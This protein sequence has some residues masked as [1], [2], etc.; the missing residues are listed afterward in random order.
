MAIIFGLSFIAWVYYLQNSRDLTKNIQPKIIINQKLA[1]DPINNHTT[2]S[3]VWEKI[4]S[5]SNNPDSNNTS[6]LSNES[7]QITGFEWPQDWYKEKKYP[8]LKSEPQYAFSVPSDFNQ[9]GIIPNKDNPFA[10]NCLL[11]CPD[12]NGLFDILSNLSEP[13][14]TKSFIFIPESKTIVPNATS[15]ANTC[16]SCTLSALAETAQPKLGDIFS[17]N[18]NLQGLGIDTGALGQVAGM[19]CNCMSLGC[20]V[21]GVPVCLTPCCCAC[22][23]AC[24]GRPN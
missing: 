16:P 9:T 12:K 22:C 10:L 13:L 8:Y 17:I 15:T 4:S 24:A 21:A 1:N 7:K 2:T 6:S 3:Q 18:S 11:N 14:I 19:I 23:A 5:W 20:I